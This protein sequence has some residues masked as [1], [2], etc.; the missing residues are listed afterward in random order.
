[1]SSNQPKKVY[2]YQRFSAMTLQSLCHDELYFSDPAA[3]N[4]PLDCQ[5]TV[6]SDS[7]RCT[8]RQLLT[9]LV[10]RRVVA[11][12]LVALT[13]A[14]LG[15]VKAAAHAKRLGEQAVRNEL[16]NIEYNATN[17]EY[18]VSQE[19]A[20]CRL[21]TYEIQREL[22]KQYDRGVC[23]FSVS[24]NNP[25]LWSHYGDQHRGLCIGYGF[26]RVPKPKLQKVIY[27]GSRTVWTSLIARALLE[28]E[29]EAQN[30]L[31]RDVLL[32]KAP[33]WRYEREWRLLGN[34][35]VQDSTLALEDLTFGLRCEDALMHAV[36]S[37]LEPREESVRFFKMYV[38]RGTFKLKRKPVDSEEI[39]RYLPKTAQSGQEIFGPF[40]SH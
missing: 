12:T 8:L 19:E 3:F 27:G 13:N 39:R 33:S 31:D 5:P 7:D 14:R 15:G 22:L 20:E 38:V 10:K 9:E 32:R 40:K 18:K 37:S 25:L 23:C 29:T 17:P 24:V 30:S 34:R 28:K 26:D 36:I 4:D 2:R 16:V 35:G 1:M 6:E 11:E 21:L